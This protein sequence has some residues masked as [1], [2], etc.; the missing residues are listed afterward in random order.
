MKTIIFVL[1]VI[2]SGIL[3]SAFVT[4]ITINGVVTWKVFYKTNT[5]WFIILY[6]IVIY[7]YNKVVYKYEKNMLNFLDDDYCLA[8]I[9]QQCLPELVVKYKTDLKSGKLPKDVIDI[10]K[11][12]KK[13]EKK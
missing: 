5:F 13:F 11:E 3:C 1:S 4:E 10:K 12:L 8:Y 2:L 6:C 9:R 7:F